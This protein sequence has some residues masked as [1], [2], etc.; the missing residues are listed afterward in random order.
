MAREIEQALDPVTEQ[1]SSSS[2][3]SAGSVF[4]AG[5]SFDV[6]DLRDG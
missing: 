4:T 5:I 6:E 2:S 1:E 3:G